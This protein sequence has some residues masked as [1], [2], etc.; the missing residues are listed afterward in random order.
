MGG[1]NMS[2]NPTLTTKEAAD[3]LK[4]GLTKMKQEI[5]TGAIKS[6]KNGRSRRIKREWLLEYEASLIESQPS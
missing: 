6:Y 1:I 5:K 2:L 4:V 3:Y